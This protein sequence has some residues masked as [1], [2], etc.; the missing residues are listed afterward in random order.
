MKDVRILFIGDRGVGKTS[1]IQAVVK[2]R[3]EAE[4]PPLCEEVV[5]PPDITAARVTTYVVDSSLRAQDE[6]QIEEEM[7]KASVIC[8]VYAVDDPSSFQR[9]RAHWLPAI[10]HALGAGEPRPH[11][12]VVLVGNKID[13]RGSD[14]D[15]CNLERDIYPVM[16]DFS[17]VETC[18][19]C[20]AKKVTNISELISF[21]QKAVLFPSNPVYDAGTRSLKA[22]A[23]VALTR[24]FRLCDVDKDGILNDT[25]LHAFQAACFHTPL[26]SSELGSLKEVVRSSCPE[27]V[28]DNGLTCTGFLF[29]N[30]LF[31]ERGHLETT[32]TVLRRYGYLD[33]LT[34]SES[35]T[36]PP[37]VVGRD[38]SVELS[39]SGE[40]FL[41]NLFRRFD[42]AGS[43]QLSCEHIQELWSTAPPGDP[44]ED[45]LL[46]GPNGEHPPMTLDRFM[47]LWTLFVL[48][49]PE[50]ALEYFA[51]LGYRVHDE[52]A[53]DSVAS[54]VSVQRSRRVD[55]DAGYTNRQVFMVCVFGQENA[56]KTTLLQRSGGLVTVRAPHTG[57]KS[58]VVPI[59]A[60]GSDLRL[61]LREFAVAGADAD[62][63]GAATF[64][65][66]C[67]V[68]L[69]LYD[70]SDPFAFQYVV[71]L[72][73]RMTEPRPACLFVATKPDLPA[74]PQ[75]SQLPPG[76]Y[77]QRHGLAPPVPA[78]QDMGSML[79]LVAELCLT[80]RRKYAAAGSGSISVLQRLGGIVLLG[81][82]V[83]VAVL[84]FKRRSRHGL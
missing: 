28:R 39:A 64:G 45:Y 30:K 62:E 73:Q 46:P 4:V 69:F 14:H 56:G 11:V 40:D 18:I 42:K 80:P 33:D 1:L 79:G 24:V 10:R 19:E 25:E 51:Y 27:G 15:G 77:C 34:L 22:T 57:Q 76:E 21:A 74:Q 32:W 44:W 50:R 68:A 17:E 36:H 8:V 72:H 54:A 47:A 83:A 20:S 12:P 58:T 31:I 84:A 63:L 29:L 53:A 75:Q 37:L 48:D 70:Q 6:P 35:F 66:H 71:N 13:T 67:D 41:R 81:A 43:G 82:A 16:N 3:F 9:L 2:E 61:V 38:C 65:D 52:D 55:R 7:R 26:P 78:T 23:A 60:R 49:H 59:T 5:I